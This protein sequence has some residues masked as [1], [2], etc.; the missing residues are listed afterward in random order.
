MCIS[1]VLSIVPGI[2]SCVV[3]EWYNTKNIVCS[4]AAK[5]MGK[6]FDYH[7]TSNVVNIEINSLATILSQIIKYP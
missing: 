5:C 6:L 4:K 1:L 7:R 2:L 3:L